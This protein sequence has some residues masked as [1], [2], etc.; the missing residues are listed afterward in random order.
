MVSQDSDNYDST[1]DVEIDQ[2]Q[3]GLDDQLDD[4]DQ[5]AAQLNFVLD[6]DEE[7]DRDFDSIVDHR[8]ICNVLE[9]CVKYSTGHSSEDKEWHPI[10]L[11]KDEDPHAVAQYVLHNDLVQVET[12]KQRRWACNFM[13]SLKVT[14]R[15][16]RRT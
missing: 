2:V 1:D 9:L 8:Y 12:G 11:V 4:F 3:P 14:L 13:R 16:M 6:P 7:K 10:G 5:T 15:R